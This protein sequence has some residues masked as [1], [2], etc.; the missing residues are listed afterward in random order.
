MKLSGRKLGILIGA[1]P[2]QRNFGHGIEL[3]REAISAGVEVYLYFI[4]DGVAELKSESL[5][6]LKK[7]GARLFACAYSLQKRNLPLEGHATPAGL[8]ML[9]DIIAST[10][11]FV[12]FS[13]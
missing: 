5:A 11:R 10:D 13:G 2:E 12:S 9:N 4:D 3:A 7:D 1:L 6:K 8:T